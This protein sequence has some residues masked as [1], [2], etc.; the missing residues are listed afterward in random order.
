MPYT[1]EQIINRVY[2]A[3]VVGAGGA[4]FPSHLKLRTSVEAVIANGAECEPLL[5]SDQYV[6]VHQLHHLINGLRAVISATGAKRAYIALKTHYHSAISALEPHIKRLPRLSLH[7][8][9]N[10]YPAGDEH[11]LVYEVTGRLAPEGGIP[12]QVGVLVNNVTTLAQI[13]EAL[14]GKAVT[15][16]P[17]TVMGEVSKPRVLLVPLGTRLGTVVN[18]AGGPTVD[19]SALILGGPMMGRP[20]TEDDVITKT[21]G[22]IIV[23]PR[24]HKLVSKYGLSPFKQLQRARSACEAC[25]LCTDLCPRYLLGHRIQ[26]HL[27][28]RALSHRL[29][30]MPAYFSAAFLCCQCGIC[31]MLACPCHLSPR[32]LYASIKQE[33]ARLGV[34]NPL[35]QKPE[36]PHPDR[37]AR[38]T[39]LARL[40]Q[41]LDITRYMLKPDWNTVP[42]IPDSVRLKLT[43]HIGAPAQPL[44]KP[45][46][47]VKKGQLI[48]QPPGDK[49]GAPIHASIDGSVSAVTD[50]FVEIKGNLL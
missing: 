5:H 39:S 27:M 35:R 23:L 48:A 50:D 41:S 26:P 11:S 29:E 15:S 16:R 10:F 36:S 19:D 42:L 1:P 17:V 6:M 37:E 47:R 38:K 44:V 20:A 46:E 13:G 22:G 18:A 14:E 30:D 4:G 12:L 31:D 33:F 49:M 3:G 8:L 7:L 43:Q 28:I 34:K 45:G 2:A 25:R 21:S 32:A 40:A 9:D 24:N